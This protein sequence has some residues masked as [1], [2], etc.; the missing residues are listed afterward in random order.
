MKLDTEKVP[1]D[2]HTTVEGGLY[3][4]AAG[5]YTDAHGNVLDEKDEEKGD[6]NKQKIK[7]GLAHAEASAK[8]REEA[9]ANAPALPGSGLPM[10]QAELDARIAL[11]VQTALA[12]NAAGVAPTTTASA[13]KRGA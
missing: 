8:K 9:A 5:Q 4:N 1:A 6:E 13:T 12:R 2:I 3:R 10:N 11:A 7:D